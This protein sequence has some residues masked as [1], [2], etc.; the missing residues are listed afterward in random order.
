[1]PLV[2]E[3]HATCLLSYQ[4]MVP[5]SNASELGAELGKDIGFIEEQN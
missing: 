4:Q 2:D 5:T 1:M 3:H